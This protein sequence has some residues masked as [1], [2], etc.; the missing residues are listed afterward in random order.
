MGTC[1]RAI[2]IYTAGCIFRVDELRRY[3]AKVAGVTLPPQ[4][5]SL[6]KLF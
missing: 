1:T 4:N 6:S 2:A 3:G 5:V